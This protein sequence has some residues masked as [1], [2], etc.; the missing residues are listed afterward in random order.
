MTEL[1]LVRRLHMY[2]GRGR[3]ELLVQDHNQDHS[4]DHSQEFGNRP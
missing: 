2:G 4:Q 3:L 1:R